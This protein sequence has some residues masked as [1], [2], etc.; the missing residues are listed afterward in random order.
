MKEP[1]PAAGR[2]EL[3]ERAGQWAVDRWLLPA[4]W[5]ADRRLL[6]Y[7]AAE[8]CRSRVERAELRSALAA[9][10]PGLLTPQGT[11]SPAMRLADPCLLLMA[12]CRQSMRGCDMAPFAEYLHEVE[13]ALLEAAV[14]PPGSRGQ[15]LL[16]YSL[17]RALGGRE[18]PA[19]HGGLDVPPAADVFAAGDEA[20]SDLCHVLALRSGFGRSPVSLETAHRQDLEE[21]LAAVALAYLK[22][23]RLDRGCQVL[24]A[25]MYLDPSSPLLEQAMSFLRM[26]QQVSGR[27]GFLSHEG[28]GLLAER[29]ADL[30]AEVYVPTTLTCLWTLSLSELGRDPVVEGVSEGRWW[31]P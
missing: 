3:W 14:R 10:D 5:D 29:Q 12:L 7:V 26:Q 1:M 8:L 15:A 17:F 21:A 30:D 25:L 11:M 31:V 2:S 18:V 20:I 4:G 23:Y 16:I 28:R 19:L 22:D 24:R 6:L 9:L 13:N 27:F